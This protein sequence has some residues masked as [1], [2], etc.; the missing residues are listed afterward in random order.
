MGEKEQVIFQTITAAVKEN[1]VHLISVPKNELAKDFTTLHHLDND[2]LIILIILM[3][4][5]KSRVKIILN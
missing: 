2:Q 5:L 4:K 3:I 1:L